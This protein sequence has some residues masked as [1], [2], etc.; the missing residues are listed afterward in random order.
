MDVLIC[1]LENDIVSTFCFNHPFYFSLISIYL[2]NL[3]SK[4]CCVLD[5]SSTF[6]VALVQLLVFGLFLSASISNYILNILNDL[7][8]VSYVVAF[9]V[10]SVP[11]SKFSLFNLTLNL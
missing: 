6:Y 4:D 11:Y 10:Y 3:G 1:A 8:I 5:T 2:S 7:M 9:L